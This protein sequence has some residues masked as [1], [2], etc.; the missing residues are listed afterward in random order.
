[1]LAFDGE[2]GSTRSSGGEDGGIGEGIGKGCGDKDAVFAFVVGK[3][4]KRD[5]RDC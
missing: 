3:K 4:G 5:G 2:D 1:M